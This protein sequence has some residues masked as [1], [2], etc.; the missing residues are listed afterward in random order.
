LMQHRI[1]QRE[2]ENQCLIFAVLYPYMH[3]SGTHRN[4]RYLG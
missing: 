1:Q 4:V 2:H 3:S